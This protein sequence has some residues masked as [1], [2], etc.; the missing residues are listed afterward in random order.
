VVTPG[1]ETTP[2]V[3]KSDQNPLET[4]DV[5][6]SETGFFAVYVVAHC[7]VALCVIVDG[8]VMSELGGYL[9]PLAVDGFNAVVEAEDAMM[10]TVHG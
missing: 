7:R 3:G 2:L 9:T 8:P 1:R 5:T 4:A 10:K 6:G